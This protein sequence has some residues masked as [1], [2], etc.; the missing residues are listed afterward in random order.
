MT[1]GDIQA[2]PNYGPGELIGPYP[3]S[4]LIKG[5]DDSQRRFCNVVYKVFNPYVNELTDDPGV[6]HMSKRVVVF[7]K[8]PRP[9]VEGHQELWQCRLGRCDRPSNHGTTPALNP[10]E[11]VKL[12]DRVHRAVHR[13]NIMAMMN[14]LDPTLFQ[15]GTDPPIPLK[16]HKSATTPSVQ[17]LDDVEE[18]RGVERRG[19]ERPFMVVVVVDI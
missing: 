8:F 16:S 15:H 5:K 3:T 17:Y 9:T 13:V 6:G 18:R 11:R 12:C 19:E 7:I 10:Y 14:Q 4:D 2:D 1:L